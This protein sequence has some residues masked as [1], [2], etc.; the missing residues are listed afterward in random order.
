MEIASYCCPGNNNYCAKKFMID[1]LFFVMPV[2]LYDACTE[3]IV[4]FDP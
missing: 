4:E 3:E 1:I 2:L